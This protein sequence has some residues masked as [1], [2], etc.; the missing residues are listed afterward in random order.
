MS[1]LATTLAMA[2]ALGLLFAW[3]VTVAGSALGLLAERLT[4]RPQVRARI[5]RAVFT[6]PMISLIVIVFFVIWAQRPM[7]PAALPSVHLVVAAGAAS[8]SPPPPPLIAQWLARPEAP[9]IAAAVVALSLAGLAVHL[10]AWTR[11]RRRLAAIVARAT[12][13]AASVMHANPAPVLVS[14][15]LAQPLLTGG[16]RPVVLV[17]EAV[18]AFAPERLGLIVAHEFAHLHRGDHRRVLGHSLIQGLFWLTPLLRV[19]R[20]RLDAAAEEASDEMALTGAAPEQRRLYAETLLETLRLSAGPELQPAFIGAGRKHHLMRMQAILSPA[21]PAGLPAL[22]LIGGLGLI[23]AGGAVLG[24]QKAAAQVADAAA[25]KPKVSVTVDR[26]ASDTQPATIQVKVDELAAPVDDGKGGTGARSFK[27]VPDG[28]GTYTLTEQPAPKFGELAAP[29]SDATH[30]YRIIPGGKGTSAQTDKPAPAPAPQASAQ[31][32]SAHAFAE[33]RT[34]AGTVTIMADEMVVD[35]AQGVE[36][37]QGSP[38]I[39]S[40]KGDGRPDPG[41]VYLVDGKAAPAGFI[42]DSI[43]PDDIARIEI[44]RD[45]PGAI[46]NIQ[47]KQP[48]A[49]PKG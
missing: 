40:Q 29:A 8:L 38:R 17:P 9:W 44:R 19:A 48:A 34:G 26:P 7:P 20:S 30:P 1:V 35:K 23:L 24:A 42:P 41:V 3:P 6:A 39:V 14:D 2:L 25:A 32:R 12:P 49:Q 4:R 27:V 31:R 36:A 33:A 45:K 46:I 16:R 21:K 10:I 13:L 22:I 47:T 18:A 15:E 11:S 5:W 37:W 28:K 43:K